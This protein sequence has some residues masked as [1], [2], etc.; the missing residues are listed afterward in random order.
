MLAV[1]SQTNTATHGLLERIGRGWPGRGAAV[2]CG[3]WLGAGTIA[4]ARGLVEAGY[5]LPLY[6]FD[7]WKATRQEVNK[8]MRAGVTVA[9]GDDLLPLWRRNVTPVYGNVR[10]VRTR[11]GNLQWDGGPIAILVVD[12]AKTEPQFSA[13]M[14]A[15]LPS[16]M[17]GA[18]VALLD[19]WYWQRW[20]GPKRHDYQC[21]ERWIEAQADQFEHVEDVRDACG[22]L[23]RFKG[24]EKPDG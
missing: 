7:R 16:L 5:D 13:M 14:G 22:A 19:Y 9:K 21:Q 23:F 2:E 10:P 6:V 11:L 4:L 3:A 15:L 20:H 18:A 17:Q 24:G 12:A 1:P 8:A